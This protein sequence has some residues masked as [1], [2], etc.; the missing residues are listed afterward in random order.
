[1][2]VLIVSLV[3]KNGTEQYFA[4]L[5]RPLKMY[6]FHVKTETIIIHIINT[7][8]TLNYLK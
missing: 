6:H 4:G 5:Y 2:Y 8:V 1:M 7:E 3:D